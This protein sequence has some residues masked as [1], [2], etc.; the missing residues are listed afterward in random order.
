M[1]LTRRDVLRLP[2]LLAIPAA[3]RAGVPE[4]RVF[5]CQYRAR[6]SV[7]MLSVP[8]LH[9]ENVGS[10][11]LRIAERESGGRRQLQLEFGAGSLPERA[12]GLN[13]LGVFE[14]TVLAAGDG[15]ES[16][17]YFGF[18]TASNEKDLEQARNALHTQGTNSFTAIRGRIER[19]QVQNRLLRIQNVA[20][21]S[22]AEREQLTAHIRA[23]LAEEA[24]GEAQSS[25]AAI[26]DAGCSP[27]LYAVHRAMRG[28][29]GVAS[30]R[31]IHNG[32][33]HLLKTSRKP[34]GQAGTTELE[35]KILSA[36]GKELSAFRM[37]FDPAN[38]ER[39]PIRFE[40]R[41]RS[42][43]RLTFERV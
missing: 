3:G 6:A 16:A 12:A 41:P 31:F 28:G 13:R 19:G 38:V 23:K 9:R 18:M 40:F 4:G 35:G 2:G 17:R 27:F 14:E 15:I 7:L 30:H 34:G 21:A 10:G 26:D 22:W 42:F 24:E 11:Y 8:L 33:V 43:L 20:T 25:T 37:W 36:A 39:G 29:A 1:G 32:Q 5:T